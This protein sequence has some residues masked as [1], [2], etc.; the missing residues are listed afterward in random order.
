MIF[1]RFVIRFHRTLNGSYV[2]FTSKP[3]GDGLIPGATH[4]FAVIICTVLPGKCFNICETL[5]IFQH[6]KNAFGVDKKIKLKNPS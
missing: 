5:K 6:P 3:E 2:T 4:K 1:I